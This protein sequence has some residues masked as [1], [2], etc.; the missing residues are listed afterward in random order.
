MT[1]GI[2]IGRG[3]GSDQFERDTPHSCANSDLLRR[4]CREL[5]AEYGIENVGD[6]RAEAGASIRV[7]IKIRNKIFITT[8]NADAPV[9][10]RPT[11]I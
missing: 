4:L 3:S 1:S 11:N 9:V 10:V 7:C 5:A 2:M 6:R 8:T